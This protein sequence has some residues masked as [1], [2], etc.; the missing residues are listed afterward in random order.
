MDKDY[1]TLSDKA[2]EKFEDVRSIY[3]AVLGRN[4]N[5]SETL[6]MVCDRFLEGAERGGYVGTNKRCKKR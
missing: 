2:A 5:N 4:P 1:Y 3:R 6:E